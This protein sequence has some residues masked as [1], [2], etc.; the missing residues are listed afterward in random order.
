MQVTDLFNIDAAFEISV[1][2]G[3]SEEEGLVIALEVRKHFNHPV[4]HPS[5]QASID[6]G[7]SVQASCSVILNLHFSQVLI[8][9]IG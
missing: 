3:D 9:I 1:H 2:K 6:L 8:D 4:Y 7:V 5:S